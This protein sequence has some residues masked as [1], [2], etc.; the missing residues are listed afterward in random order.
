MRRGELLRPAVMLHRP[1]G[2]A[3]RLQGFTKAIEQLRGRSALRDLQISEANIPLRAGR[4]DHGIV[5]A[6]A[7]LDREWQVFRF[8]IE[9]R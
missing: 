4:F 5:L 8:D 2:I 6:L 3:Q 9:R 1:L 7:V